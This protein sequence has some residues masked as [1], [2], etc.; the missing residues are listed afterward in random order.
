MWRGR[1]AAMLGDRDVGIE[2]LR[3]C[4]ARGISAAAYFHLDPTRI[5]LQGYA[6]YD[7]LLK[8]RD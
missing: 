5:L 8:S 7:N 3:Q 1:I 2:L 4:F 6:P